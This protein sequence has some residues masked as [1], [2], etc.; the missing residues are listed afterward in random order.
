MLDLNVKDFMIK[1]II[2]DFNGT[3]IFDQEIIE[4]SWTLFLKNLIHRKP[5]DEEFSK[6]IHGR[7]I[8]ESIHYFLVEDVENINTLK[9]EK[10]IIYR[11]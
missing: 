10:E 5:T 1:A 8:E 7:N 3:M 6:Y 9:L 2:F 4:K 11:E